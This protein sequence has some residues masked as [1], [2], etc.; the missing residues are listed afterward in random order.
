MSNKSD[1]PTY[2]FLS[3]APAGAAAQPEDAL[4]PALPD[5]I[6][7]VPSEEVVSDAMQ[8]AK[9]IH[10]GLEQGREADAR[11]AA[12]VL[13]KDVLGLLLLRCRTV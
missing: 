4:S 11:E 9:A 3:V 7:S 5:R 10:R 6:W 12:L 2:T 1:Y 8:R 13:A